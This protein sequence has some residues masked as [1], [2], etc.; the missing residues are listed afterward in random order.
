MVSMVRN[1]SEYVDCKKNCE[2]GQTIDLID[3]SNHLAFFFTSP[4]LA[5][6]CT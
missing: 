1:S 4:S 5:V 6:W 3:L 2:A